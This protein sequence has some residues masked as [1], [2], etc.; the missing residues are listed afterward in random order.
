ME[1]T[2]KSAGSLERHNDDT[3]RHHPFGAGLCT[4]GACSRTWSVFSVGR[5]SADH[6]GD[7][8]LASAFPQAVLYRCYYGGMAYYFVWNYTLAPRSLLPW[9]RSNR[10]N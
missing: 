4:H 9:P 10:D 1:Y 5:D 7:S 6:L 3:G 2:H 8:G